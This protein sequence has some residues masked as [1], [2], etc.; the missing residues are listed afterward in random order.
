[1]VQ[2]DYFIFFSRVALNIGQISSLSATCL[3]ELIK[4]SVFDVREPQKYA[5]LAY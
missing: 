5:V 1:M 4:L 3:H 2:T